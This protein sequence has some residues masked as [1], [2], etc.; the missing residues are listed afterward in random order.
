MTETELQKQ[1]AAW[2]DLK[3]YL[4]MHSPNEGKRSVKY[5][6]HLKKQGLKAGVPDCLIFETREIIGSNGMR[7]NMPGVAIELKIGKASTK[8]GE[9]TP[10][11]QEWLDALEQRGWYTAVCRSLDEVIELCERMLG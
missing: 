4:W 2:L 6:S 1:V 7:R 10:A 8:R 5:G 9:P 3:G 11:Q